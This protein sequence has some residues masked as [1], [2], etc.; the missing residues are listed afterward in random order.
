VDALRLQLGGTPEI[1]VIVGV[2]A[3]NDNVPRCQQGNKT[4][5]GGID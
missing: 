3:I 1:I 5:Q 4:R 2:A